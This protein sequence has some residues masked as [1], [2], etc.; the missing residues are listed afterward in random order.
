MYEE[1][2]KLR[3]DDRYYHQIVNS[4]QSRHALKGRWPLRLGDCVL[5]FFVQTKLIVSVH[6]VEYMYAKN[7]SMLYRRRVVND[8]I[9]LDNSDVVTLITWNPAS[10][11]VFTNG[12]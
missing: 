7:L 9:T 4:L 8:S 2:F 3:I 1:L 12:L 11:R 5:D 6:T 10:V